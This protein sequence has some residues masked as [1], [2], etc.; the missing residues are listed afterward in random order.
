[1]ARRKS[2]FLGS[3]GKAFEVFKSL[4]DEVLAR[5][6]GDEDIARIQSDLAL[7]AKLAQ[8]IVSG[9]KVVADA[10][11]DGRPIFPVTIDYTQTLAQMI[12]SYLPAAII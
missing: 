11:P 10:M 12:E 7:R 4:T 3:F 9:T 8:L 1:M 6:G 5:G 2:E